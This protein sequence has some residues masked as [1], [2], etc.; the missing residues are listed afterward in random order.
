LKDNEEL[1]VP[2]LAAAVVLAIAIILLAIASIILVAFVVCSIVL[3][4]I[5]VLYSC[6]TRDSGAGPRAPAV[7]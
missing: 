4:L 5:H 1:A 7:W 2:L 6:C 3:W